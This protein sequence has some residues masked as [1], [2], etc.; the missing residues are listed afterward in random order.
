[1]FISKLVYK[2]FI[3]LCVFWEVVIEIKIYGVHYNLGT[4]A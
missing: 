1:M 4:I 2:G 3:F